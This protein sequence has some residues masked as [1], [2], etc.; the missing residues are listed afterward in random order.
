MA[1]PGRPNFPERQR[2]AGKARTRVRATLVGDKPT[3][4]AVTT[5]R[6]WS[7]SFESSHPRD[8]RRLAWSSQHSPVRQQDQLANPAPP[9]AEPEA[10]HSGIGAF[11]VVE[12]L[13]ACLAL[14]VLLVLRVEV[15]HPLVMQVEPT[16]Q[17]LARWFDWHAH[18]HLVDIGGGTN[19]DDWVTRL[20]EYRNSAP[21]HA[22]DRRSTP[23]VKP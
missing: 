3:D 17:G 16:Q 5:E 11:H 13:A 14:Q 8:R 22:W 10:R 23:Y 6:A 12:V 21:A 2:R 4:G 18:L 7:D 1:A 20:A 19:H 15:S 9:L